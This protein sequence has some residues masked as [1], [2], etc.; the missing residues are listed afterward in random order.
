MKTR[1]NILIYYIFNANFFHHPVSTE[2]LLFQKFNIPC[3]D[4]YNK[5]KKYM[6]VLQKRL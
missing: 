5:Q 3:T 1:E 2:D 4:I 6:Y